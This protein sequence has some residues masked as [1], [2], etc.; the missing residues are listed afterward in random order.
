P[1]LP[2]NAW[3]CAVGELD[4]TATIF[5]PGGDAPTSASLSRD[6][7]SDKFGDVPGVEIEVR[8]IDSFCR[9]QRISAVSLVKVDVEGYE[10]HALRGMHE[11]VAASRPDIL[12]EVLPGQE[13]SLRQLVDDLWPG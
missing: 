1:G 13:A 2:I 7:A 4:G 3:P 6:F 5:D 12:L 10:A 11:I 9:E 8:S